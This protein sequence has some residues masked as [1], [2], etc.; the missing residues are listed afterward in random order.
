MSDWKCRECGSIL[1]V[2]NDDELMFAALD[3]AC[4]PDPTWLR[5]AVQWVQERL[6]VSA[7][8]APA[9]PRDAEGTGG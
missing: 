1:T 7:A 9:T 4:V 5:Q 8:Q 3:H 6:G 2:E